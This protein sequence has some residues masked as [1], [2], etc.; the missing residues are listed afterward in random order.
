MRSG[1]SRSLRLSSNIRLLQYH[2]HKQ[3]LLIPA[4][5][6]IVHTNQLFGILEYRVRHAKQHRQDN[7]R[8]CYFFLPIAGLTS[9]SHKVVGRAHKHSPYRRTLVNISIQH[10]P[11]F[12][13][14]VPQSSLVRLNAEQTNAGR[15]FQDQPIPYTGQ[16]DLWTSSF[17]NNL[18]LCLTEKP[19]QRI[20]ASFSI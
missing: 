12:S 4:Q 19:S 16:T 15:K 18:G 8:S 14:L 10:Y 7:P 9:P 1:Q 2:M 13:Y 11:N 3:P 20:G 17:F 5:N 6:E